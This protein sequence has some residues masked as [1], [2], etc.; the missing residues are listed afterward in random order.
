MPYKNILLLIV[1]LAMVSFYTGCGSKHV[2]PKKSV[3]LVNEDFEKA[4]L[5]AVNSMLG[6]GILNRTDGKRYVMAISTVINDTTQRVDTD[7]LI[8]KIRIALLKSGNVIVTTAI[9]AG[10]AEDAM[11]YDARALRDNEEFNQQ[12]VPHKGELI[13][14]ELSLS[15]KIIQRDYTTNSGDLEIQYYFQL[16]LTNVRNGLAIWEGE[17]VISKVGENG[18]VSW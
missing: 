11:S 2:A 9:G 3:A 8:K 4:A 14:P 12:S 13:A 17:T 7:Q 16:T 6:S 5:K 10:G 15:G 1:A 18:T